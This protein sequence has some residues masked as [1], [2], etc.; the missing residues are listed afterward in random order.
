MEMKIFVDSPLGAKDKDAVSSLSGH[1][2]GVDDQTAGLRN[3]RCTDFAKDV[4]T[5]MRVAVHST[6]PWPVPEALMVVICRSTARHRLTFRNK[7]AGYDDCGR[8][9][10]EDFKKISHLCLFLVTWNND[11]YEKR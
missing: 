11:T 5:C 6:R 9:R 8:Y 10:E 1:I 4:D 7:K 3:Y 2:L